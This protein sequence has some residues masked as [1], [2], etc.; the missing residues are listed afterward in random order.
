MFKYRLRVYSLYIDRDRPV[1]N[2]KLKYKI[3]NLYVLSMDVKLMTK[4]LN[5]KLT[6]ISYVSLRFL[7]Q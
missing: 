7:L 4:F 6:H 5:A 1:N 2:T 3:E